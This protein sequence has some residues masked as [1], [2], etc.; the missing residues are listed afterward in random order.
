M[1][2][3]TRTEDEYDGYEPEHPELI[4]ANEPTAL[5]DTNHLIEV[6]DIR[7]AER[8]V[9]LKGWWALFWL[10]PG[11]NP[12]DWEVWEDLFEAYKPIA[13]EA[14]RRFDEGQ[15]DDGEL[16]PAEASHNP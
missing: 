11:L 9:F 13:K 10:N 16:Y 14:F 7:K 4:P 3:T 2:D 8:E 5:A 1:T 12:D 15:F 6:D